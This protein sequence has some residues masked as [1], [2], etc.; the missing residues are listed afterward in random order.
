MHEV[1]HLIGLCPDNV[2]HIDL[3][4]LIFT[5]Y[6]PDAWYFQKNYLSLLKLKIRLIWDQLVTTME[7]LQIGLKK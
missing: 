3:M 6:F 1:L 7:M 2:S 4:D 5:N